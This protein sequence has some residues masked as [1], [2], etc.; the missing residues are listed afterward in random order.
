MIFSSS[1]LPAQLDDHARF[2]LWHEVFNAEIAEAYF[3]KAETIPFDMTFKGIAI[4]PVTYSTMAGTI[5]GAVRTPAHAAA[6]EHYTVHINTSRSAVGGVHE[7]RDVEIS[8]GGALV[9]ASQAQ[10]LSG[11]DYN[12]W[13]LVR[14]PMTMLEANF[15]GLASSQGRVIAPDHE[16]LRLL[17]RYVGLLDTESD[18]LSA[19]IADHMAATIVDLTGLAIG[20]RGDE[21]ELAGMRG[22]R[23]A[24]LGAV[25]DRI[26]R[27][28]SRPNLSAE[29]VGRELGLSARYI[30]DLLAASGASFSERVLELRLQHARKMLCSPSH[31]GKRIGE[32]VYASGFNDISYFNRCF[33]RRFGCTPGAA[34]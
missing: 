5:N 20:V 33:R 24:R 30:Q 18:T 12:S 3:S 34:R 16:A 31:R 25:L 22:L 11:G 26:R 1:D 9:N 4:G 10:R 27:D 8:S 29:T 7:K 14:I 23:R 6:D 32:I 13:I 28:Y 17:R 15:S 21:A 2:K 19:G